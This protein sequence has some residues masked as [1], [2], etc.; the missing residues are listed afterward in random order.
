FTL[1]C[2]PAHRHPPS[3]P[4]RRSSDL[5]RP[6]AATPSCHT[7]RSASSRACPHRAAHRTRGAGCA[8]PTPA[9]TDRSP[10]N[11]SRRAVLALALETAQE[12]PDLRGLEA[13]PR[14]TRVVE[15]PP[16]GLGAELVP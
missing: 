1:H 8:R 16:A 11:S 6:A 13:L 4:T 2:S 12:L 10:G 3:F 5:R 9:E 14:L 15:E 7:L